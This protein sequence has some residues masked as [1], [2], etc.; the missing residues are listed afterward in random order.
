MADKKE[1]NENRAYTRQQFE[2]SDR[3]PALWKALIKALL[4]DG[5]TYTHAQVNSAVEKYLRQEAK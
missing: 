3:Y 2:N 4:E 1:R 5:R